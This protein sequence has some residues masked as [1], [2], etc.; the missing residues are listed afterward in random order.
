[1][2]SLCA[3]P[4]AEKASLVAARGAPQPRRVG[5]VEG[6][7][8]VGV[9]G[10]ENAGPPSTS[11]A[12][13]SSTS[14]QRRSSGQGSPASCCTSA[15]PVASTTS[16]ASSVLRGST[17]PRTRPSASSKLA[18]PTSTTV[19]GPGGRCSRSRTA[20]TTP[21]VPSLPTMSPARS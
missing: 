12:S 2:S 15:M 3:T 13:S 20:V 4:C 7:D 14:G 21:R 8:R 9:V 18:T 19:V 5:G 6:R 17:A 16:A 11:V 10:S 1:M